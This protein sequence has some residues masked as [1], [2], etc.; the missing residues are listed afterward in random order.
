M[1]L[2]ESVPT[3]G[4]FI[5]ILGRRNHSNIM[6]FAYHLFSILVIDSYYIFTIKNPFKL[7][8]TFVTNINI[9]NITG[10]YYMASLSTIG[11]A[12]ICSVI[13][14]NTYDKRMSNNH[15]FPSKYKVRNAEAR[16]CDNTS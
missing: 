11:M 5:P 4:A 15:P 14:L 7:T 2:V 9:S 8:S 3:S 1:I 10:Q 13:V 12:S 6:I 16:H